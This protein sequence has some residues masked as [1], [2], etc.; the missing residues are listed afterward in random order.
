MIHKDFLS[1]FINKSNFSFISIYF[2][3]KKPT[4]KKTLNISIRI[5]ESQ[6]YQKQKETRISHTTNIGSIECQIFFSLQHIHI[7][8]GRRKKKYTHKNN[9]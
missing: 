1:K 3:M 6:N 2:N 4:N 5:C 8:N 7:Y 9:H